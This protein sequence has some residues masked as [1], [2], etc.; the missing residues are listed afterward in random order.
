MGGVGDGVSPATLTGAKAPIDNRVAGP[1]GTAARLS[2]VWGGSG[3]APALL[4]N[5]DPPEHRSTIGLRGRQAPQPDW[6]WCRRLESKN[7][8]SRP[9]RVQRTRGIQ[10]SKN[11][12]SNIPESRFPES[13]IQ[14]A[15]VAPQP[16]AQR[17]MSDVHVQL[18][19]RRKQNADS[20]LSC[21]CRRA[22]GRIQ[23][24]E[25]RIQNPE[26]GFWILAV[27]RIQESRIQA[28]P[29]GGLQNPESKNPE[30]GR[31]A[32]CRIQNPRIQNPGGTNPPE[33]TTA[34][35]F[36]N[37]E[38]RV[39]QPSLPGPPTAQY[40][41][42]RIQSPTALPPGTSDRPPSIQNPESRV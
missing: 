40:P 2:M 25:S 15:S 24:P 9:C 4:R 23:N 22:L 28:V 26:S 35:S 38:S 11:P 29:S 32:D 41:E 14:N 16:V 12:R 37:P 7:P 6:R 21:M 13:R 33:H 30:S 19:V 8:E 34:P 27:S 31:A 39:R 1:S 36:Q 18:H 17:C 3:R 20:V 5:R 10:E 42:S